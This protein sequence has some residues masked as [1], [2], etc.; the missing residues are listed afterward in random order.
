LVNC[1]NEDNSYGF[2]LKNEKDEDWLRGAIAKG[3]AVDKA[4]GTDLVGKTSTVAGVIK[5]IRRSY[6]LG[7]V[8]RQR[9]RI[10]R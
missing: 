7:R 5:A 9:G 4:K 1:S 8:P 6:I 3:Y 10:V 2:I